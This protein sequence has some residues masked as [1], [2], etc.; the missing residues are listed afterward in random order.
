MD[1]IISKS[2]LFGMVMAAFSF[3]RGWLRWPMTQT[4][5][6]APIWLQLFAIFALSALAFGAAGLLFNKLCK[7]WKR[8]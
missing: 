7:Y 2:L 1:K 3:F 8:R 6:M 4:G 5:K